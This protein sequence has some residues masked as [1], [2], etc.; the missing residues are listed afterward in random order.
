LPLANGF[1][2][3]QPI[4]AFFFPSRAVAWA[5]TFHAFL[6]ANKYFT[7]FVPQSSGWQ[8]PEFFGVLG[9]RCGAMH[10]LLSQCWVFAGV[11]LSCAL[12]A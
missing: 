7:L 10:T 1:L 12:Q 3:M 2:P 6:I 11:T 4:L 5:F 8:Q 9:G